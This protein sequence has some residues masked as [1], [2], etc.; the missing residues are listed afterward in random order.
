MKSALFSPVSDKAL[1]YTGCDVCGPHRAA[2][3][4]RLTRHRGCPLFT[5]AQ[6]NSGNAIG[7]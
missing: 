5:E 4:E 2:V 6:H 7:Q 3:T 1:G